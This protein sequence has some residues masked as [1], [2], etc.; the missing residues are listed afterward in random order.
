MK[1]LNDF[2]LKLLILVLEEIVKKN[3]CVWKTVWIYG[4]KFIYKG[5]IYT[6][7]NS[8][9]QE[10]AKFL[11]HF[12]ILKNDFSLKH[13]FNKVLLGVGGGEGV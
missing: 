4:D 6:Y 12:I 5:Y 10:M 7:M 8:E 11:I 2:L 13:L 3:L 1:H 9:M